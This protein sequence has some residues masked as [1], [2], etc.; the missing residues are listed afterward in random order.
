MNEKI[1]YRL[2]SS[3]GIHSLLLVQK[4]VF[5]FVHVHVSLTAHR[6]IKSVWHAKRKS[7]DGIGF[8]DWFNTCNFVISLRLF[9]IDFRASIRLF[10]K[11]TEFSNTT[12]LIMPIEQHYYSSIPNILRMLFNLSLFGVNVKW[13]GGEWRYLIIVEIFHILKGKWERTYGLKNMILTTQLQNVLIAFGSDRNPIWKHLWEFILF[14]RQNNI[15]T[16]IGIDLAIKLCVEHL[17]ECKNWFGLAFE[18]T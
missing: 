18:R 15:M 7:A 13:P 9:L 17:D 10:D 16:L 5:T 8:C 2:L 4:I 1:I 3:S 12:C 11:F 14:V 6:P